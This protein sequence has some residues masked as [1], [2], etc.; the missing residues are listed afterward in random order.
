[1]SKQENAF[2]IHRMSLEEASALRVTWLRPKK[3]I[4]RSYKITNDEQRYQFLCKVLHKELTVS[5]AALKFGMNYTTAKNVLNLYLN[6]GRI[7]KKKQRVRNEKY[8]AKKSKPETQSNSNSEET[9]LKPKEIGLG[10]A[11]W[12]DRITEHMM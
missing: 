5:E 10:A 4:Q 11:F 2:T 6:E 7:E 8:S 3:S 12:M 1:M 9:S